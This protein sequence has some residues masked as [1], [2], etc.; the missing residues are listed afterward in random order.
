MKN[1]NLRDSMAI[2][3]LEYVEKEKEY[4]CTF[5]FFSIGWQKW[6][7]II[8]IFN[9]KGEFVRTKSYMYH[10]F[11]GTTI[12]ETEGEHIIKAMRFKK[13]IQD[14]LSYVTQ[15]NGQEEIVF[16][17]EKYNPDVKELSI[18]L[19]FG[20]MEL[21]YH[22]VNDDKRNERIEY[23]YKKGGKTFFINMENI[24]SLKGIGK[25]IRNH[26]KIRIKYVN[27]LIC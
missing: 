21:S 15:L 1:E 27:E 2:S 13:E 23:V 10:E 24:P 25:K 17:N 19:G 6:N 11:K 26:P 9:E 12:E 4:Q 16:E 14:I 8:L 18:L 20:E 5:G 3:D 7:R 22:F